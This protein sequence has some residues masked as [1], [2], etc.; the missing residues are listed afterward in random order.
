VTG[1][2]DLPRVELATAPTPLRPAPQL[3]TM[4]GV[5][6]WFKRD[7]LTG[8]GLGGNK[9]RALEYLL[10][11]ALSRGSDCLVTGSG[12]QSNWAMLAALA[13]RRCGLDAYLAC[14]GP[15]VPATGNLQLAELAGASITFTGSPDRASVDAGI[16]VL[17]DELRRDGR[18]PC[19][20][21][22]GGAT[23][24]GALG[25]ARASLELAE[26]LFA[27]GL[28]PRQLWLATGSGGTQAGLLAGTR[29]LQLPF[30]VVGVTVSRPAPESVQRVGELAAGAATLLSAN[31]HDGT[32][33]T[34]GAVTVIDGF[35]GPAY[36]VASAAGTDAA[37]LVA[38]TEGV[39]LDPV[40][41]AKAMAAL[42]G[43]SSGVVDNDRA[44][45]PVVFLVTGGA[46][47]LFTVTGGRT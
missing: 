38:H 2:W 27:T 35:L 45:G 32:E 28:R 17:A 8:F 34:S 12:P 19:V 44:I 5:E 31:A 9:V 41:G 24:I 20:L 1:L 37:R 6:I 11:D 16:A 25:Y 14:Y 36:G 13:A 39:F 46:P 26:Q 30:E 42:I 43:T 29:W 47:T 7:D 21:P 40:F 18:R 15:P 33:V 22:R 4:L 3:S 23:P 10:G